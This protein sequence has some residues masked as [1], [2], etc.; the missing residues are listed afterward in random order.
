MKRDLWE[1]RN[2]NYMA[3]SWQWQWRHL[4]KG[5]IMWGERKAWGDGQD[6]WLFFFKKEKTGKL[7]R[8]SEA[9]KLWKWSSEVNLGK[10]KTAVGEKVFEAEVLRRMEVVEDWKMGSFTPRGGQCNRG[11]KSGKHMRTYPPW[12]RENERRQGKLCVCFLRNM[13][14]KWLIWIFV[15]FGNTRRA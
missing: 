10:E 3:P 1:K 2:G 9:S 11:W 12:T 7:Q 15:F 6:V 8:K 14:W 5:I 13:E 4:G